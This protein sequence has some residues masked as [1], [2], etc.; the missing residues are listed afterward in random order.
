MKNATKFSYKLKL[1]KKKT[2]NL[3]INHLNKVPLKKEFKELFKKKDIDKIVSFMKSD[4][5]NSSKNINIILIK[6]FGQIKIN[7]QIDQNLL[8]RFLVSELKK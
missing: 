4:K 8:N 7:Y 6:N 3:I 1:L 2:Y 5:K